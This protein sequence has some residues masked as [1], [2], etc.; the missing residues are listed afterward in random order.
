MAPIT[1]LTAARRFRGVFKRARELAAKEGVTLHTHILRRHPVRDI[2]RL[3]QELKIELLV[4]GATG[5][6][7]STSVLLDRGPT[8]SFGWQP[9][10]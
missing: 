3:V 8:G 10:R 2:V 1:P 4:V 6:P 7:P 9:G 5:H